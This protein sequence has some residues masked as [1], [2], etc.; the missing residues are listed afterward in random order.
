MR[1]ANNIS[2]RRSITRYL[3]FHDSGHG[4]VER[5][6]IGIH[7]IVCIASVWHSMVLA[8]NVRNEGFDLLFCEGL[9][10]TQGDPLRPWLEQ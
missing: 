6:G 2:R 8:K 5:L 7:L 3:L 10:G 4:G 9:S 1:L